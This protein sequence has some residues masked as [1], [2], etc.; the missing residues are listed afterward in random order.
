MPLQT[1]VDKGT[2]FIH[3]WSRGWCQISLSDV[4]PFTN[5]SQSME[6][7]QLQILILSLSYEITNQQRLYLNGFQFS[8]KSFDI[9]LQNLTTWWYQGLWWQTISLHENG[10]DLFCTFS[11]FFYCQHL[12]LLS[13]VQRQFKMHFDAMAATNSSISSIESTAGQ[14]ERS[15][16]K[17]VPMD[18][19]GNMDELFQKF[20]KVIMIT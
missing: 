13:N 2:V 20:T 1:L 14:I 5:I 11:R 15:L 3:N 16:Q 17:G 19:Q 8:D 4:T 12:D 6:V 18:P 9:K 7:L 10:H